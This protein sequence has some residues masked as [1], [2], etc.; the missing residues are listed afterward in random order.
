MKALIRDV[1]E[2]KGKIS[3]MPTT[4]QMQAWFVGVA[5]GLVVLV[6]IIARAVK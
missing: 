3:Q 1:S 4:F 2:I 6:F 5:L